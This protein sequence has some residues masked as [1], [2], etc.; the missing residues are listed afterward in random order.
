MF[1]CVFRTAPRDGPGTVLKSLKISST[2]YLEKRG[3][4]ENLSAYCEIIQILWS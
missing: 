3:V 2:A 1:G 4:F